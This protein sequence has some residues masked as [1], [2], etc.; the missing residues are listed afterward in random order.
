MGFSIERINR[1][2]NL[3]NGNINQALDMLILEQG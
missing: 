3:T 2:L 1:A